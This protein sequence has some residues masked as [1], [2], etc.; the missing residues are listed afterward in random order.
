MQD[1]SR[2]VR[3]GL[4]VKQ[5]QRAMPTVEAARP[6]RCGGCG[7]ASR[8][9]GKTLRLHGHGVRSRLLLG[10]LEPGA[11][12]EVHELMLRRYRCA[13]C[14]AITTVG[15]RELI[16]RHLYG[17]RTILLALWLWSY[18]GQP[19]PQVRDQVRP[20]RGSGAACATRWASLV[21]WARGLPWPSS[22]VAMP[23]WTARRCAGRRVQAALAGAPPGTPNAAR[24][25]A[26]AAQ[27]S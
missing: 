23:G 6:S 17:V 16:R 7:E 10:L 5:W 22:F 14:G 13:A 2:F 25:M 8:P 26:G 4:G 27:W 20:W 24:V 19:Q 3:F 15:P 21:R 11:S 18:E 1:T 12:P 9:L